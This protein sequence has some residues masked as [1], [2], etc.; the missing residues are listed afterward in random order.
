MIEQQIKEIQKKCMN[1]EINPIYAMDSIDSLIGG[2]TRVDFKEGL[3]FKIDNHNKRFAFNYNAKKSQMDAVY[4]MAVAGYFKAKE[5]GSIFP[6]EVHIDRGIST[7]HYMQG[8]RDFYN[9]MK[10]GEQK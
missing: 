5:N 8:I 10:G 3:K 9:G 6:G 4:G 7:K 2:I 1:G